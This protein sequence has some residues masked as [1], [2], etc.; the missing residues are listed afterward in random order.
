[1]KMYLIW[2]FFVW[3]DWDLWQRSSRL[4]RVMFL[5]LK[6]ERGSW[7]VLWRAFCLYT[8][9]ELRS[10]TI[11]VTYRNSRTLTYK[12]YTYNTFRPKIYLLKRITK[13]EQELFFFIF[14]LTAF[15]TKILKNNEM[16][17]LEICFLPK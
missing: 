14:N 3:G 13:S 7:V 5:L 10:A 8:S 17:A 12:D 2:Y 6:Y 16:V 4:A 1:M 9:K 15:L 11:N